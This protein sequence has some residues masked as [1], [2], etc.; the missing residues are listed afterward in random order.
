MP[1]QSKQNNTAVPNPSTGT[2]LSKNAVTVSAIDSSGQL[3]KNLNESVT[4]AGAL[5]GS[6]YSLRFAGERARSLIWNDATQSYDSLSI[7]VDTTANTLTA[8]VL[9][10]LISF[11]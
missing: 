6:G 5:Y 9:T 11:R 4:I 7:T 8:T 10:S 1:E 2:V 3:I